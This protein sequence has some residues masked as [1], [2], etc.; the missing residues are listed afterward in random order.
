[1]RYAL[2]DEHGDVVNLIEYDGK[3]EF[4]PGP[5]MTL[6]RAKA[7]DVVPEVES[8]PTVATLDPATATALRD[9][10]ADA[11]TV[12]EIKAAILDVFAPEEPGPTPGDVGYPT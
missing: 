7:K 3:A 9:A 11:G 4:D 5:G 2:V 6:R 1:M 8:E 10:L 12:E